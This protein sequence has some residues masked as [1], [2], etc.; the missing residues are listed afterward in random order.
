MQVNLFRGSCMLSALL[1]LLVMLPGKSV[2]ADE[3]VIKSETL[4]R[5]LERDTITDNDALIVPA[6]EYIQFDIQNGDVSFHANGWGRADLTDNNYFSDQTA[7]ELLYGYLEYRPKGQGYFTRLGRQA[8]F[9]GVANESVDGAYLDIA[10]PSAMVLSVYA[11]Q[12]VSLDS[13]NGR[14]GDV[15]YGGRYSIRINSMDLGGS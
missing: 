12:P 5:F 9:A 14:D 6:Y 1:A 3:I 10:L 11:G 7:G 4:L 2:A 15:I 8:V 13:T